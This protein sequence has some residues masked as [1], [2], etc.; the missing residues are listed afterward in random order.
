MI[1]CR[2]PAGQVPHAEDGERT[3]DQ[4]LPPYPASG[5]QDRLRPLVRHGGRRRSG[6]GVH[7]SRRRLLFVR[8]VERE[9]ESVVPSEMRRQSD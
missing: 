1:L 4:Q 2:I 6:G 9:L 3:D 8:P 5:H 7:R